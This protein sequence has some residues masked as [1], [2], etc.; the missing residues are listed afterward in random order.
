M[1]FHHPEGLKSDYHNVDFIVRF[2]V[3]LDKLNGFIISSSREPMRKNKNVASH[4]KNSSGRKR[5]LK[6]Y[7]MVP[8]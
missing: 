6:V 3:S 5:L 7:D 4:E 2:D 1:L 8:F